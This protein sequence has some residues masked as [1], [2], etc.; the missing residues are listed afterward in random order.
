MGILLIDDSPQ[1]LR[2]IEH[3]LRKGGYDDIA[4]VSSAREA[5]DFL[6]FD[7][8]RPP[9][10]GI[11]LIL[12]DILM[13]GISG[14]EACRL[15]RTKSHL[16]DIPIIMITGVSERESLE[17]AFDAGAM[18]YISKPVR[19]IELLAR[20]RSLIRLK[21][22]QDALRDARGELERRVEER[23]VELINANRRLE[24]EIEERKRME[25]VL[26]ASEK[27]LRFLSSRLIIAQEEERKSIAREVH[28][29]IGS[30]LSGI[31]MGL[32]NAL[33]QMERGCGSLEPLTELVSMVQQAMRECR[34]IMTDLRPS[35]LDDYG[36]VK[37]IG[38]LC[39]RLRVLHPKIRIEKFIPLEER[40]IPEP[41]KIVIFRISQEA[42][43]NAAKYSRAE[44]LTISLARKD[45]RL[46]E[47][48]ITD[49]GIGFD[50]KDHAF[51]RKGQGLTNMKERAELSG[52]ALFIDS[53]PEQGTTI[54][55]SWPLP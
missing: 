2:L 41:L 22:H 15:L 12:M 48:I 11:D 1:H 51:E 40:E 47:L 29:S 5:F 27:R 37:T 4:C 21:H 24:A 17:Q 7:G 10:T 3:M 9:R 55:A 8:S 46:L 18:D 32:E 53:A 26:H 50:F 39:D 44:R 42:C 23:T 16:K 31:K 54:R 49:N 38:W 14:I 6:G 19:K 36:I 35:V 30:L 28:D 52:G 13:P 33:S 45:D 43:H 25:E 34:R 20:V